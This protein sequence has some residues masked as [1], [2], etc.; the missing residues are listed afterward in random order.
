MLITMNQACVAG[1]VS[2]KLPCHRLAA[3][4]WQH[5][6]PVSHNKQLSC[7]CRMTV[8]GVSY[9]SGVSTMVNV[10]SKQMT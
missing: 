4:L 6:S 8:S 1:A 5:S 2:L 7:N 10:T 3:L 9:I